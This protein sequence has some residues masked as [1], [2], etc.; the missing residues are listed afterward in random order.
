MNYFSKITLSG[1]M[2]NKQFWNTGSPFQ[3]PFVLVIRL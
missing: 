3:Q 2:G 1:V